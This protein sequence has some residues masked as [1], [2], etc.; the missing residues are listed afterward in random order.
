MLCPDAARRAT[1]EEVA[2]SPWLQ[3]DQEA[4]ASLG[5]QTPM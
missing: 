1:T 3:A 5:G 4:A 2:A